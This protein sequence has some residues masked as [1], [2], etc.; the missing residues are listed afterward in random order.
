MLNISAQPNQ[1]HPRPAGQTALDP[2]PPL[3]FPMSHPKHDNSSNDREY[4]IH[5]LQEYLRIQTV[6]PHPDYVSCTQFLLKVC[7]GYG[8][9]E[10]GPF[11]R[12][13]WRRVGIAVSALSCFP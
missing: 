11:L 10:D 9:M 2:M 5:R 12:V 1:I 8:G 7:S 6:Q 13:D 3:N 4:A